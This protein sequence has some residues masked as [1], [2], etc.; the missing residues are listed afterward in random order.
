[1]G[2]CTTYRIVRY[3]QPDALNQSMFP[4]RVV[5][6]ADRPFTFTRAAVPRT[7][8]ET[9]TVRAADATRMSFRQYIDKHSVLA[10]VVIRDDTILYE[11][12]R[13]PLTDS[14]IHNSF[15]VAKSVLSALVGIA[16]G[17][18]KLRVDDLVTKHIPELASRPA[19]EG[20][21]VRHLLEMK[22]GLR[23]TTTG[24]GP[25][26]DF[27]SDEARVYYTTDMKGTIRDAKRVMPPGSTWVYKDIDAE[28][29]GWVLARAVGMT[30][31]EY[32]ETKLWR[33]IGTE[34]D[35]KWHLDNA[36]GLE[37]TSGGF[38]ATARDYARFGRLFLNDGVFEGEQIVPRDWVARSVAV[39]SSRTEPEVST[40]W[41]MQ[42]TL[43]WW[44]PIQPPHGDFF[45]DGSEGQRIYVDRAT[46]T[47]IVQL[48]ND[49]RQDFPFRRIAS[50]LAGNR[51]E[52]P[53]LIP[54]LILQAG[55]RFGL[56]SVRPVFTR[57]MAQRRAAPEG[58]VITES[59]MN[60]AGSLLADDPKTRAA[61]IEVLR[62]VTETYPSSAGGFVRL[63]DA[64]KKSGDAEGAVAAIRRA[65][66]LAP[67]DADVLA[68]LKA[69]GLKK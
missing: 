42:H 38:N 4:S 23:F 13:R 16:V 61:G 57:L 39:D 3:R 7:D 34:R 44:H 62:L 64:Y 14:T 56:D 18:G 26:S 1:V 24:G 60:T 49:S 20:V 29:L 10:F 53:R 5:R 35:A 58:F 28:L 67:S 45:A 11:T 6:K 66:E 68:R 31:A 36:K 32:T 63:S 47:I 40:W 52:Y 46:R 51:W 15:S 37:K 9:L 33:R 30:V 59:G 54:G 65:A 25:W 27:R 50:Y 12:Y 21:T 19:F 22:S 8:I 2:G 55:R 43:Y 17:D 41:Q 48:A 69:L